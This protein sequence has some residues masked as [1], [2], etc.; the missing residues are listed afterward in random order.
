MIEKLLLQ[1]SEIKMQLVKYGLRYPV[2][3]VLQRLSDPIL[4]RFHVE[5][6]HTPKVEID[7][8]YPFV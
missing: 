8:I 1:N 6:K 2:I 4:N 5:M 7:R 3:A